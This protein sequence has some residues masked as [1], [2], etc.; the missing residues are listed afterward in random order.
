MTTI[1]N[2]TQTTVDIQGNNIHQ[3]TEER[4]IQKDQEP[5][6][7]KIWFDFKQ[8]PSRYRELFLQ[9]AI[10]MSYSDA[11]RSDRSQIV[12]VIGYS[13]RTIYSAVIRG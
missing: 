7:I 11:M 13:E 1:I 5:D 8:L 4:T 9:L 2:D 12:A 10:R 6:C 3:T